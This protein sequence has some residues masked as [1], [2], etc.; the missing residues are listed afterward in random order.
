MV[1]LVE[2][3]NLLLICRNGILILDVTTEVPGLSKMQVYI[4]E[5]IPQIWQSPP[6][7]GVQEWKCVGGLFR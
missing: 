6:I 4:F 1:I 5:I 3:R 7:F 2:Q